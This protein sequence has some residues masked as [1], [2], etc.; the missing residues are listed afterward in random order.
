MVQFHFIERLKALS[1]KYSKAWFPWSRLSRKDSKQSYSA[2]PFKKTSFRK[3]KE[4]TAK[5]AKS[6]KGSRECSQKL[7]SLSPI[8][9]KPILSSTEFS[10]LLISCGSDNVKVTSI[11]T[12]PSGFLGVC[13]THITRSR[14]T[15]CQR[16]LLVPVYLCVKVNV[17][18]LL[19][20]L[21]L[22]FYT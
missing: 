7:I 6:N 9:S 8:F 5:V 19:K 10:I 13:Y 22:T 21:F 1:L 11:K 4:L 20:L 16:G 17:K 18:K 12:N 3:G 14:V 2:R 15:F